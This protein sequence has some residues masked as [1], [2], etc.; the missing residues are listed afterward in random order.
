MCSS[1]L[2]AAWLAPRWERAT[3]VVAVG[4]CGLVT[5]L[6]APLL[7]GKEHDPA[8][9]VVDP[10]GRYAIALLGGH[11]AGGDALAQEIAALLGGEAVLTGA[12]SASGALA[13]DAFGSAWG[14]SRGAGDWRALM[15]RSAAGAALAVQQDCGTPLWRSLPATTAALADGAPAALVVSHRQGPGCRWHPPCQIGRAHV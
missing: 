10:G 7:R 11:A 9:V 8:V 6:I 15:V 12:S 1:D 2:S 4:A 13:L 3:A 14:W 5:R